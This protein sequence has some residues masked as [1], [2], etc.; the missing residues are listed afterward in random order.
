LS[1]FDEVDEPPQRPPRTES[2]SPRPSGRGRPPGDQ[3]AIQTRRAVALVGIV[4]VIVLAAVGIH[5]CDDSAH[6]SALRNYTSS[7]YT[8]VESSNALGP[9]Q[10]FADLSGGDSSC[11]GATNLYQCIAA[12]ADKA[13]AQ[14]QQSKALSVPGGMQSAQ[15]DLV[16][17]MRLRHD[18]FDQIADNVQSAFVSSSAAQAVSQIAVGI[19]QLYAS[20]VIYKTY[21]AP[22]IAAALN[23]DGIRATAEPFASGQL[24]SNLDWLDQTFIA[25]T[26][27]AKVPGVAPLAAPTIGPRRRRLRSAQ[28]AVLAYRRP[29]SRAA[30]ESLTEYVQD[31][32]RRLDERMGHAEHRLDGASATTPTARCPAAS[33]LSIA[34]LD[35]TRTGIVL[36]SIHHRD[37]AR[38]YAK[39][40]HRGKPE[41]EL[42]P[43]EAEAVRLALEG[44]AG[45]H[46]PAVVVAAAVRC[47]SATSGP[48]ARSR[49]RRCSPRRARSTLELVPLPTIYDT[50]MAVHD[51]TV[52][53]ALVPIENSLEGSVNATLDAL[54]MRPRTSRS[55]ARSVHPIRQ[56]LIARDALELDEIEVV[57]RIPQAN[58]SARASSA[59][60]AGRAVMPASSTADAV[61]TVAEHDGPWAALGNRL[62]AERYG[63]VRCC[64]P[65]SRTSPGT[66]RGSCG[67]AP[68]A[69]PRRPARPGPCAL[70]PWKTAIVFWGVGSEA[71]GWLVAACPSSPRAGR[72]PDPDRV[73]PAQAGA[74]PLHVLRRPRGARQRGARGRGAEGAAR[75]R[76]GLRVLGSFP[77]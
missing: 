18:G 15:R 3:Q 31:A 7:V 45:R 16:E 37:Q 23:A 36:S 25:Q 20:D 4:V 35:A 64:G 21:A 76:R 22:E 52:E 26:M 19:S 5:S 55:S 51:G 17:T 34:L 63:C 66:R 77:A 56:C 60:A 39:Q 42:S 38:L 72:Q 33:R 61:R 58:A 71:P 30:L 59:P 73:A 11:S 24:V 49:T 10:L 27:G 29:R 70:G 13:S 69:R 6:T 65:A 67:S 41:L 40:V 2:R 1:F 48:R 46:R 57:S 53:R 8:I 54:A 14:L 74:R 50:V 9:A 12:L 28:K 75:A 68:G 62:A 47:A 44:D 43:E 32:A